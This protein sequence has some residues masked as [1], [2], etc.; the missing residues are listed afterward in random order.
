MYSWNYLW[1]ADHVSLFSFCYFAHKEHIL[2]YKAK[3]VQKAWSQYLACLCLSLV[4]FLYN[5]ILKLLL[6]TTWKWVTEKSYFFNSFLWTRIHKVMNELYKVSGW[7]EQGFASH[8]MFHWFSFCG[9]SFVI[10]YFI[11]SK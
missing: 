1:I 9:F 3:C 7:Q 4:S 5:I 6:C 11:K 2:K 10:V 8:K